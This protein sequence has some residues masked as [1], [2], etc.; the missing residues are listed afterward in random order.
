[1][2]PPAVLS[3]NRCATLTIR[4]LAI[5]L[6]VK[7]MT[8]YHHV[9]NKEAILDGMVDIVFSEIDLPP[10]DTDWKAAMRQRARSAR[11]VLARHPWATPL[12][13]SRTAPGA[14]TLRHHDAVI[15]CFRRGGFSIAMAAHAYALIDCYIYG[16]ALQEANLPATGG[17]EMADLAE[18]IIEQLPAGEYP[19]LTELT[20]EHVL[21]P[22]Y[23]FGDE[24][25]FGLDLILDG[26]EAAV[27]APAERP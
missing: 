22:G 14:T 7:P 9:A 8:I 23:D 3:T 5:E 27:I 6:D 18:T 16:F 15:G 26:L 12:M 24:F 21:Q 25:E 11:A 10:T 1:M 4:K 17:E 13:E 2:T 19:H 20:A